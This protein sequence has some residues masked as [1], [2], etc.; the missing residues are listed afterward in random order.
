MSEKEGKS[1]ATIKY[2]DSG[3]GGAMDSGGLI[4]RLWVENMIGDSEVSY[5]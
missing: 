2:G 1:V 5:R 4:R 3:G